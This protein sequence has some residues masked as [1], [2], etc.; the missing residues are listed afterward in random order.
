MRHGFESKLQ[1]SKTFKVFFERIHHYCYC[2][3]GNLSLEKIGGGQIVKDVFILRL[4][5]WNLDQ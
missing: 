2:T 4:S 3:L 5:V 1:F